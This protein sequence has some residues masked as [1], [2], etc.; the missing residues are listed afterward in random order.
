MVYKLDVAKAQ[1]ERARKITR[2]L[3][4]CRSG[5]NAADFHNKV[6]AQAKLLGL[7][8]ST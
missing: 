3:E 8:V 2:I 1:V 7:P 5:P 4:Q 6:R